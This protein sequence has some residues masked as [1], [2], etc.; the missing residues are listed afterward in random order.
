M[1]I[2]RFRDEIAINPPEGPTFYIGHENA[3]ELAFALSR[4]A[5]EIEQ[6]IPFPESTAGTTEIILTED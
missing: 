3:K 2:Y 4:C 1:R 6:E 5:D